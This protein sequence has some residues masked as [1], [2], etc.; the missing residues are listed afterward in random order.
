VLASSCETGTHHQLHSCPCASKCKKYC[1]VFREVWR[2]GVSKRGVSLVCIE[3]M[4]RSG[5]GGLKVTYRASRA[6]AP[7]F[8]A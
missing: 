7:S 4:T 2:F 6:G 1:A 8:D 5:F 3:K